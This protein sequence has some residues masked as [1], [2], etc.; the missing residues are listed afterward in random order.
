L[1]SVVEL[2]TGQLAGALSVESPSRTLPSLSKDAAELAVKRSKNSTFTSTHG[3]WLS[4]VE[5]FF[6]KLAR[7]AL[8]HI[9]VASRHE[10]KDRII[11]AMEYFNQEPV[12]HTWSFKL[13]KTA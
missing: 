7:S 9:R 3:S 11:A 4:L 8:R 10:P 5:G 2:V 13:D 1:K 12:V 6:S